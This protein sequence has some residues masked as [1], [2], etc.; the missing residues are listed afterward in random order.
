MTKPFEKY[1]YNCYTYRL[2]DNNIISLLLRLIVKPIEKIKFTN[3]T[4]Q[5]TTFISNLQSIIR[6]LFL[7]LNCWMYYILATFNYSS[8]KTLEA[9]KY[10]NIINY[11]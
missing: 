9:L 7:M 5:D 1:L 6:I 8:V 3:N 2:A 4:L 10:F 11:D